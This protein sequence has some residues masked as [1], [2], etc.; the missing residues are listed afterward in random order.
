MEDRDLHRLNLR[1]ATT[2]WARMRGLLFGREIAEN[3]VLV[4]VPCHAIHT[5]G[6]RYRIDVA[7]LDASGMVLKAERALKKGR[8]RSCAEALLTLERAARNDIPW[9]EVGDVVSLSY[10]CGDRTDS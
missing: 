8:R 6:M 3:E 10:M 4:L 5:F 2:W 7:F 1:I 9:V